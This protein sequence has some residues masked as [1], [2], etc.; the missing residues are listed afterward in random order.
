M[1]YAH[2]YQPPIRQRSRVWE[3]LIAFV[4][5]GGISIGTVFAVG[6]T[7][8][9]WII[10]WAGYGYSIA[11]SPVDFPKDFTI[12]GQRIEDSTRTTFYSDA[13]CDDGFRV[14]SGLCEL[15]LE[16]PMLARRLIPLSQ[17]DQ[18][19]GL[20]GGVRNGTGF[21]FFGRS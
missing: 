20:A 12:P 3:L 9:N 17:V 21:D 8:T 1:T 4:A 11:K 10:I 6:T 5:G 13:V 18:Y 16:L 15:N 7:L 14:I 19:L 2:A